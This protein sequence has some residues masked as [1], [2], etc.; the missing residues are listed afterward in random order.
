M[1]SRREKA[2]YYSRIFGIMKKTF[3]ELRA[4]TAKEFLQQ[5]YIAHNEVEMKLEELDRLRSL[6]ERTTSKLNKIF[7]RSSEKN[8]KIEKAVVLIEEQTD[9][10]AEEILKL[11]EIGQNVELAIRQVQ[12]PSERN[13][14]EYRY[15]CF[16][17]WQQIATLMKA[18][19][20]Q[21]FRLHNQA[22]E[23]FGSQCQ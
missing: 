3:V 23:N 20:R 14:L 15:L 4:M 13:L 8:S 19:Q 5:A 17:S 16:F 2:L 1:L 6:S 21:I 10:L 12:N 11:L 22:L 9:R 18:S 7:V